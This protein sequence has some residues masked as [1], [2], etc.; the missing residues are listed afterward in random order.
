MTNKTIKVYLIHNQN[1]IPLIIEASLEKARLRHP[2]CECGETG[3]VGTGLNYSSDE[4][5]Y[6]ATGCCSNCRKTLGKIVAE[7]STIFGAYEDDA[8]LSGRWR[9]F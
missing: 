8:V 3:V 6:E 7:T 2:V 9:V 5:S 1:K 4:R